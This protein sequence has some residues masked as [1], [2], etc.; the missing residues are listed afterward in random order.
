MTRNTDTFI[1][2][3]WLEIQDLPIGSNLSDEKLL[4]IGRICLSLHT[5]HT[6]IRWDEEENKRFRILHKISEVFDECSYRCHD[7]T[8]MSRLGRFVPMMYSLATP[9]LIVPKEERLLK[10]DRITG[11]L[12]DWWTKSTSVHWKEEHNAMR[13]AMEILG[14]LDPTERKNDTVFLKC[15]CIL[16]DW[17]QTLSKKH[18]WKNISDLEALSRLEI[19]SFASGCVFDFIKDEILSQSYQHYKQQIRHLGISLELQPMMLELE[20]MTGHI[21]KS[22]LDDLLNSTEATIRNKTADQDEYWFILS[23]QTECWCMKQTEI[24]IG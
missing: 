9:C 10:C 11:R 1:Q 13:S 16:T 22:L 14:V 17:F 7:C 20:K 3:V 12:L 8:D 18:E 6:C 24:G 5:Q 19:I 4:A 2:S 21:D 23:I 15:E